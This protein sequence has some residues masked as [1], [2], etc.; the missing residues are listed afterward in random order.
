MSVEIHKI[1]D[2][3]SLAAGAE[4]FVGIIHAERIR[5]LGI[6]CR[7]TYDAATATA[8]TVRVYVHHPS[9]GVDTVPLASF[10]VTLT[11][12]AVVQRTV[13]VDSIEDSEL[14]VKVYNGD[15]AKAAT[16]ISVACI[17][18]RWHETT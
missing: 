13:V 16:R 11:A 5:S 8:C 14:E 2:I 15:V 7:V 3:S 12:G 1:G 18:A 4:E 9:I 6:T 10:D 17:L